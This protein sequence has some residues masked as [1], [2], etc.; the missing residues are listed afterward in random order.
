MTDM[1]FAPVLSFF[2]RRLYGKVAQK[3]FG[4]GLLYIVYLA[5]LFGVLWTFLSQFLLL[6][7]VKDFG[8]WLVAVTPETQISASGIEIKA[9]EPYVIKHPAIPNMPLV[10][11]DTSLDLDGLMKSESKAF[12]LVGKDHVIV[13]KPG[14]GEQR[15]FDLR[16]QL[17]EMAKGSKVFVITKMMMQ[18][19]VDRVV[20]L[21]TPVYVMIMFV[22]F[23]VWKVIEAFFFSLIGLALNMFRKEKLPYR[24]LFSLA[25][26][27][28]SPI[29]IIQWMAVFAVFGLQ[30]YVSFLVGVALTT[31]YMVY[32]ML[33][34]AHQPKP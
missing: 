2:S 11:I 21:L 4:Y 27:A 5:V 8:G 24:N 32:G 7:M 12:A 33:V 20:G 23:M 3:G 34:A 28:N 30:L 9:K 15:I 25:C 18:S 17:V 1:L 31:V 19:F 13:S 16:P 29:T 10:M 6:P 26:F 22:S 14:G